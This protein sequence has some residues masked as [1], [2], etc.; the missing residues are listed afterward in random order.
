MAGVDLSVRVP[1]KM[2]AHHRPEPV[3]LGVE[4]LHDRDLA[5]HDRRVGGLHAGRLAQL[6]GVQDLLDAVGL[7]FDVAPAC[8]S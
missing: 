6:L 2:V 1:A 5:G 7:G 3:D 4:R 8:A